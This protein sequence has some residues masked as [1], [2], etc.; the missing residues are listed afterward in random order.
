MSAMEDRVNN[1]NNLKFLS[2]VKDGLEIS[3]KIIPNSSKDAVVGYCEDYF[4]VKIS[5][6]AVENKAN[7]QLILFLS[8]CFNVPKSRI[9]FVRG[10]KSKIKR[11]LISGVDF[12]SI[13]GKIVVYDKI[14]S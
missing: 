5:S 4:K 12:D 1:S 8:D 7:K 2:T 6:P 9:S 13:C 14:D 11:L 3:V 10:E